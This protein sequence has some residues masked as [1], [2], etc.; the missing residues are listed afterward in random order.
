MTQQRR[1]DPHAR[2]ARGGPSSPG[3]RWF[4]HGARTSR[5]VVA[6]L[7]RAGEVRLAVG[8]LADLDQVRTVGEQIGDVDVLVQNAGIWP[9]SGRLAEQAH[10][11]P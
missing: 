1:G 5:P 11:Q 10:L 4:D 9:A 8:D 6:D 3:R 2:V 7:G